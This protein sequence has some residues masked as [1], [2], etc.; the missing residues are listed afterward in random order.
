MVLKCSVYIATSV[1]GFIA[2]PDGDITWLEQPEY[3]ATPLQGLT[4]EDFIASVDALVMGRNTFEKVLTFGDWPY[5]NLPVVVLTQRPL[6]VPTYLAARVKVATGPPAAIVAQLAAAGKQHLYIDGG[7]TI[8]RFLRAGLIDEI[9]LT[10]IPVLLGQGIP[11]FALGE[12]ERSLQLIAATTS[13]HGLVQ[14][15]YRVVAAPDTTP[16]PRKAASN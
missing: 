14:V 2:R 5:Q 6:G 13:N 1:D 12:L 15:R 4:Y 3:R 11:L 7:V 10:Y 9:T 8:Q 16:T